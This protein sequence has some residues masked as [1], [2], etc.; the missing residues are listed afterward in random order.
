[1][2][3]STERSAEMLQRVQLTTFPSSLIC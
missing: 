2:S 3:L 1:V